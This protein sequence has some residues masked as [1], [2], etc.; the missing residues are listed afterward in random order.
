[1]EVRQLELGEIEYVLALIDQYDRPMSER[2][3]RERINGNYAAI[4]E[5]GGCVIGALGEGDKLLGTCTVNVCPNLSWSGR[6]YAIIENVIVAE[7][8]RGQGI[9]KAV[10]QYATDFARRAGCYKVALMTGSKDPAIHRFYGSAGFSASKQ[11]YQVR[12][13]A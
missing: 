5:S 4:K 2:P 11:G 13:N 7:G 8:H 10:L 9:G 12:F 1:M 6:P 3:A